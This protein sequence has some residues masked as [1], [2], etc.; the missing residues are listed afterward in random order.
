MPIREGTA[1]RLGIRRAD[2]RLT[3]PSPVEALAQA[4]FS[5]PTRAE[6]ADI[7]KGLRAAAWHLLTSRHAP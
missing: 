2:V 3:S 7:A 4:G 1:K 6:W 5:A